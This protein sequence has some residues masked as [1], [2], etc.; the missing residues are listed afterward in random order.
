MSA[1]PL[2][3][4]RPEPPIDMASTLRPVVHGGSGYGYAEGCRCDECR[5]AHKRRIK[6]RV[7]ERADEIRRDPT[8]A[9]HGSNSTY[10]NWGCRCEPCTE[11]HSERMRSDEHKA[12]AKR[13]RAR[14]AARLAPDP[15]PRE[16]T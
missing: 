6:R 7:K 15:S 14:L 1:E 12:S 2:R 8:L 3:I 13:S 16:D 4:G 11:A 10:G 9:E 5:A